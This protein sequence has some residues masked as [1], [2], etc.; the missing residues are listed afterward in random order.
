MKKKHTKQRS[1]I[2]E[3]QYSHDYAGTEKSP[4]GD[5]SKTTYRDDTADSEPPQANPDMID[6]SKGLYYQAPCEDPRLE[7]IQAVEQTLTER[8]REILRMCGNEG[9]TLENTAAILGISIRAVRTTLERIKEKVA[10]A[11]K[12]HKWT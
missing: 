7:I 3:K 9:R 5:W 4:Y 6:E 12:T 2:K 11:Q 1:Y 10:V 8:Q